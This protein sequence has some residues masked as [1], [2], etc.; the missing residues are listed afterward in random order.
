MILRAILV[1]L[2]AC[3]CRAAPAAGTPEYEV[4]AAY[5]YNFAK[6]VEWPDTEPLSSL[7]VCIYGKDPFG[8]FLD[9]A[10]RGKLVHTL[11][12]A[13]RR[14]AEGDE[15][16]DSCQILFFGV[17]NSNPR[18]DALVARLRGRSILTIGET[19]G[20]A[21][22]GGMIGL[23]VDRG[24]VRFDINLAAIAE[25]RLQV[26]SRLVELGRVVKGKK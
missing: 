21:E 14:L 16:W 1:A 5:V 23:V 19:D 11:S 7:T 17:G 15:S 3:V 12:V 22:R 4:K 13:V 18:I 8:G 25:A 24:R 26:S 6:F 2:V 10:V 20:F 9:E